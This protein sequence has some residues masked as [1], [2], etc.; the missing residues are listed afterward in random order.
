MSKKISAT[1]I[2]K[3]P[4]MNGARLSADIGNLMVLAPHP[5]DESLGCGGLI[6][7]LKEAGT[8]VNVVF[9]TS[10]SASHPNS[11][12]HPPETL[13]KLREI[14]AIK[15]CSALGMAPSDIHFV[16]ASDSQLDKLDQKSKMDISKR[17][18]SLFENNNMSA[19]AMPWRRDPHPDHVMTNAIGQSVLD[20][21]SKQT[22]KIEYP[23][24]LWKNSTEEDWPTL[25]EALPYRLDIA[26]VYKKKW[27]AV[28]QHR[29]QLG[30]IIH[31]D[32]YG[33]VLTEE[34]LEPFNKPTEYFFLTKLR[35]PR[36]LK[37]EY[38]DRL[39]AKQNDP[40]D[41]RNS[42][43]EKNKYANSLKALGSKSF[44]TGLELGCSIGIQ[45]RMLSEV[46]DHLIAVDI[47]EAAITEAKL[48]C[49]GIENIDF[50]LADITGDFPN[51]TFDLITCNEI[52][53]YL[54][55]EDLV[56]LYDNIDNR[57]NPDG[58]FLMV[59]WRQFV[60]DYP[61]SGDL[62]HDTFENFTKKLGGYR[63][64]V[65]E[66]NERYRLQVWEKLRPSRDK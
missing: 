6:A 25:N 32:A 46:C 41:F 51:G 1:A 24:W 31:D 58:R 57:L 60:P 45:T 48:N 26:L 33:F 27:Q 39:Y 55:M 18:A 2:L 54:E 9:I 63:E 42:D 13:A 35:P 29:S 64:L 56:R 38:F 49:R 14:E 4:Y 28:K 5:D 61:L 44:G 22:V 59:H 37:K 7:L 10:G 65:H 20:R 21:I 23:I 11:K 50:R 30:E 66:R 53:Y 16:R 17:I 8:S 3:A 43:Y 47:S 52:G 19:L 34:L 40:W 36:T 15:A 62:V 12:T